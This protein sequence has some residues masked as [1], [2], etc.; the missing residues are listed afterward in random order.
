[1]KVDVI[2]HKCTSSRRSPDDNCD[3]FATSV[4]PCGRIGGVDALDAVDQLRRLLARAADYR[5]TDQYSSDEKDCNIEI[6]YA[7]KYLK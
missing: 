7:T 3:T 4:T 5:G 1:M 6:T 2:R